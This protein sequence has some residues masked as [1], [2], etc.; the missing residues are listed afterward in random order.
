MEMDVQE[1]KR[2]LVADD[3]GTT[4]D[5]LREVFESQEYA[6]FTACDGRQAA[7]WLER[8]G[9]CHVL[10]ADMQMPHLSGL[11]LIQA[12]KK[13]RP[14]IH[15][16]LITTYVDNELRQRAEAIGV[17]Q[18]FEKPV[19]VEQLLNCVGGL[20]ASPLQTVPLKTSPVPPLIEGRDS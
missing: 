2:I 3:D 5:L 20:I 12:V 14:S 4:R 19:N 10:L 15:C 18:V 8:E 9:P 17:D 1:K 7:D 11:Q 13:A 6:V 16:V